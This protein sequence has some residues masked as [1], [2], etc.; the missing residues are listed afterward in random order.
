MTAAVNRY[1]LPGTYQVHYWEIWGEANDTGQWLGTTAEYARLYSSAYDAIKAAD[2]S[3]Q[4][5]FTG[6]NET[7]AD[8]W[9]TA[10]CNDA[11]FP[12]KDK[13]D[14]IN[15]HM[16]GSVSHVQALAGSVGS[17]VG[18]RALWETCKAGLG[19]L[20]LWVTEFGFP[21]DPTYQTSV[22]GGDDNYVGANPAD[23]L[24][25][26]VDYYNFLIPWMMTTGNVDKLFTTDPDLSGG[27]NRFDSE[28]YI[29]S[30]ATRKPSVAA[31]QVLANTYR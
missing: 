3:A 13:I 12:A 10:V 4:V 30:D 14:Y 22:A 28:G 26:Q 6:M 21:S 1:G 23:G 27:G 24:Q 19:S 25:K 18:A 2:P 17:G 15:V 5:L 11:N 9:F 20:P 7:V 8:T 29:A 31:L 16:R